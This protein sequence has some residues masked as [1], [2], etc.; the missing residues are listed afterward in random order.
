MTD[1]VNGTQYIGQEAA[2]DGFFTHQ[3]TIEGDHTIE[4]AVLAGPVTMTGT[5]IVTGTLVVV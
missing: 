3:E 4:S 5:V 2:K 1:V